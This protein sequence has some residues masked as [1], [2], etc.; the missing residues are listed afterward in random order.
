MKDEVS[1]LNELLS[2]AENTLNLL[3]Q[4]KDIIDGMSDGQ[5]SESQALV[6]QQILSNMDS[7]ILALDS[8]FVNLYEQIFT[9]SNSETLSQNDKDIIIKLQ[10][11][12]P[13]I[14]DLR[15]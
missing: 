14:E 13:L 12:I 6:E 2:I 5:L 15:E 4:K 8:K 1:S 11:I 7:K 3:R 9:F 10:S